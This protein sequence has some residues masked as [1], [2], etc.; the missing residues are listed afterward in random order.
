MAKTYLDKFR[1]IYLEHFLNFQPASLP[2]TKYHTTQEASF[3]QNESSEYL[4][5]YQQ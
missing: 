5:L 4:D 1:L 3:K 2:K